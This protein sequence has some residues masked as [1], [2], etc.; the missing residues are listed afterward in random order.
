MLIMLIRVHLRENGN[1][2]ETKRAHNKVAAE[3]H[4]TADRDPLISRIRLNG[5]VP[6]IE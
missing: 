2:V 1:K 5:I 6:V 4:S 3:L